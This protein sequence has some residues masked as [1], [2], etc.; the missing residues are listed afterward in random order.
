MNRQFT[1]EEILTANKYMENVSIVT[2]NQKNIHWPRLFKIILCNIIG[3]RETGTLSY[4]DGQRT[5]IILPERQKIRVNA[6]KMYIPFHPPFT[7]L[8]NFLRK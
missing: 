8:R 1:K 4:P 7:L 6:L 5:F 3:Y 2:H